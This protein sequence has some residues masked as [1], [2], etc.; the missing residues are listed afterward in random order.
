MRALDALLNTIDPRA[1]ELPDDL[2]DKMID[3]DLN[4][5]Q[6]EK[7]L[8]KENLIHPTWEHPTV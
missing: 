7:V 4:L 6:Q 8:L 5:A 1:L 2:I 3:S